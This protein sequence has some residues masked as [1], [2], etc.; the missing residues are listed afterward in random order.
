MLSV[1]ILSVLAPMFKLKGRRSL[2]VEPLVAVRRRVDVH[3]RVAVRR[4][5]AVRRRPEDA[6]RIVPMA[7][8]TASHNNQ[9]GATT[10]SIMTLS[11]TTLGMTTHS[12]WTFSITKKLTLK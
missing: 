9:Q 6:I 11:I 7:A 10:L 3:L 1:V 5:V 2:D 4:Q 8:N 12:V